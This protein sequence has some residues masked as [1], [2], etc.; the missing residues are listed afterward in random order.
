MPLKR[1]WL[2]ISLQYVFFSDL[3]QSLSSG[4]RGYV[5]HLF[6]V[7]PTSSRYLLQYDRTAALPTCEKSSSQ[8]HSFYVKNVWLS[9]FLG[10]FPSGEMNF[11]SQVKMLLNYRIYLTFIKFDFKGIL[12]ST[13]ALFRH[14]KLFFIVCHFPPIVSVC[15]LPKIYRQIIN[16]I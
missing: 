14:I 12:K 3:F 8:Q 15:D 2:Y 4:I 16:H 10:N 6:F 9:S 7:V 1:M 11:Y 13:L 5:Y